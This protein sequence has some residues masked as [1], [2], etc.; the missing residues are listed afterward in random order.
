M[1]KEWFEKLTDE[2]KAKLRGMEGDTEKLIA[3]CREEKLDLP[4]DVLEAVSGGYYCPAQEVD[5]C[6]GLQNVCPSAV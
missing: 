4:D 2:Q 3:F 1:E 6:E 5:Y